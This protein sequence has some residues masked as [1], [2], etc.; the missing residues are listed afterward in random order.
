[1]AKIPAPITGLGLGF[2]SL[3]SLTL[4]FSSIAGNMLG[5]LAAFIL[6]IYLSKI[7]LNFPAFVQDLK[8]PVYSSTLPTYSMAWMILAT[9]VGRI[10]L[11]AG[12]IIWISAVSFHILLL[13]S[14]LFN[15]FKKFNFQNW[16]PSYFIPPV[17]I[18]VACVSGG[19]FNFPLMC[20][21]V[22]YFGF[23]NYLIILA[24]VLLRLKLGEI[25]TPKKPTI[26]ILAAPASLCLTGYISL[27]TIINPIFIY[28]LAPL[29]FLMILVVYALLFKLLKLKFNPGFSAYTFPLV[30]S[31]IA[32]L[33]FAE[34][35]TN[36]GNNWGGF[37]WVIGLIE[38]GITSLVVTYVGI[39]YLLYYLILSKNFKREE[40]CR[41]I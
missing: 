10:N 38:Y 21:I 28:I 7:I 9:Y 29:S 11:T 25:P 8:H 17:G 19:M 12:T 37:V 6:L 2:A 23:I 20:E 36:S 27:T 1:M 33:K 26:A 13:I 40:I 30:I 34:F 35:L 4:N 41:Q 5:I 3:G 24:C 15:T 16:I 14:F 22:F 31:A 18:I 32:M 39:R